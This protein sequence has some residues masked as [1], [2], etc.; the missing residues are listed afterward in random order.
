[1]SHVKE[2]KLGKSDTISTYLHYLYNTV[3]LAEG[4]E[5]QLNPRP[6]AA[7]RVTMVPVVKCLFD[8]NLVGVAG[9]LI[10]SVGA[11]LVFALR[12][13]ACIYWAITRIAPTNRRSQAQI[14]LGHSPR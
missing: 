1:M 9:I 2:E 11:N 12:L 3:I 14:A 5:S 13:A 8:R 6:F 4:E 7:L 10:S